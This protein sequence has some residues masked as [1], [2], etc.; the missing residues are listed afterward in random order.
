MAALFIVLLILCGLF[1]YVAKTSGKDAMQFALAGCLAGV[2]AII[3]LLTK[4]LMV[5]I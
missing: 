4:L 3:V 2:L 5:V 1:L